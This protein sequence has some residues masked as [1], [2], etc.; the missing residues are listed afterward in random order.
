MIVCSLK[1][2]NV[3]FKPKALFVIFIFFFPYFFSTENLLAAKDLTLE[4]VAKT[5]AARLFL[6]R[7]Y[8]ES[9]QEFQALEAEHPS[10]AIIKRY[11]A[12]LHST[13]GDSN[14]AI[15]KLQEVVKMQ[16]D[17]FVARQ[18]LGDLY[19]KEADFTHASEQFGIIYATDPT[20]RVGKYA[21]MRLQTL[22]H[23]QEEA[24]AQNGKRMSTQGFMQSDAAKAFSRGEYAKALIGLEELQDKYPEDPLIHRFRGIA[25]LRVEKYDEGLK[26]LKEGVEKYPDNA[27]MHYYLSEAYLK[28]KRMEDARRELRTVLERDTGNYRI[29][30]QQ[31]IFYS[32]KEQA[33]ASEKPRRWSIYSSN[34]YEYDTN[35]TYKAD[36]PDYRVSGDQNSGR[37]SSI[38]SGTYQFYQK[39]RWAVT[40]DGFYAQSLYDDFPNLNTYTP[41]GGLSLLYGFPLFNRPTF[42]NVREGQSL[43]YLKRQAYVWSNTVSPSLIYSVTR[44]FRTTLG[45]RW[46]Y[47]DYNNDGLIPD[48]TTRDGHTHT[49][50]ILN[51]HYLNEKRSLYYNFGYDFDYG[52]PRGLNYIKYGHTG[53]A[54][55]HFPLFEKFEFDLSY[56]FKDTDYPKYGYTPPKRRDDVHTITI[57]VLRPIFK[58]WLILNGFY[59]FEDCR[60][61]NNTYQY[62][63]HVFGVKLNVQY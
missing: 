63:K 42:I 18:M 34:S 55:I 2:Q 45:Y 25:L 13:L 20:S 30:A 39:N 23:A 58:S 21:E 9:L 26:V 53:R 43:T 10:S 48:L 49:G 59:I 12:S 54:G 60:A 38:F 11:I 46:T 52:H 41:G 15:Q 19:I 4:D 3:W 35:A 16:S 33:S 8:E 44:Q 57:N 36:D 28:L 62:I 24:D 61:K 56:V 14:S 31:A 37:Y 40:G 47:A 7:H 6:E 50:T 29:K 17:D 5:N 32:L 22:K 51:T 1:G 27:A